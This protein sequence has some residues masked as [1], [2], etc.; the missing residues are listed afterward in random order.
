MCVCGGGG[1][2]EGRGVRREHKTLCISLDEATMSW[3]VLVLQYINNL[4]T[5]EI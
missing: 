1:G 5:L 4:L 2:G 3:I